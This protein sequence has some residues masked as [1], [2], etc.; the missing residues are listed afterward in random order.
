M[1]GILTYSPHVL[2]K[3]PIYQYESK[4]GDV[5]EDIRPM[6]RRNDPMFFNGEHYIRRTAPDRL[7]VSNH[8]PSPIDGAHNFMKGYRKLEEKGRLR[9]QGSYS[10]NHIKSVWGK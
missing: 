7:F 10:K 8:A 3:M 6:E 5:I 1:R 9:R 4:A 2:P